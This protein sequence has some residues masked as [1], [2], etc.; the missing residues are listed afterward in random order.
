MDHS[1]EVEF[2]ADALIFV[3]GVTGLAALPFIIGGAAFPPALVPAGALSTVSLATGFAGT[4]LHCLNGDGGKCAV[5]AVTFAVGA[6]AP[7]A[8]YA[9][10]TGLIDEAWQVAVEIQAAFAGAAATISSWLIGLAGQS[11]E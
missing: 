7:A 11:G 2:V 3:S 10:K 9:S 5:G 1:S 6:A 4:G 8:G